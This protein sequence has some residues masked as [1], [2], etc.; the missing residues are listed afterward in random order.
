[1]T[2]DLDIYRTASIIVKECD[3]E[4]APLMAA[5]RA[6]AL[7]DAEDVDGQRVWRACCGRSTNWSDVNESW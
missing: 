2:S 7:L 5:K 6:D 3:P 4:Q 1:M